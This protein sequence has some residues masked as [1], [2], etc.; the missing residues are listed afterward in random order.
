MVRG[1]LRKHPPLC[2]ARTACSG[3]ALGV[4]SP[5]WS[6]LTRWA[7]WPCRS[8]ARLSSTRGTS[9]PWTARASL[10]RASRGASQ[11]CRPSSS[12]QVAA[13][14]STP[15]SCHPGALRP[16]SR[17][18]W[19]RGSR[20]WR[21]RHGPGSGSARRTSSPR[22]TPCGLCSFSGTGACPPPWLARSCLRWGG[23]RA[24]GG[25]VCT[26]RCGRGLSSP[27]PSKGGQWICP[28]GCAVCSLT[29]AFVPTSLAQHPRR[30]WWWSDL[31]Q[32]RG[33]MA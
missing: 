19:R 1:L 16:S 29:A 30:A 20:S 31:H 28:G 8:R 13:S 18:R 33:P 17:A 26:R 21:S 5:L 3:G 23:S 25:G 11:R 22:A 9:W 27:R 32:D 10:R 7:P 14:P 2:R 6:R 12:G 4:A 24:C 15:G